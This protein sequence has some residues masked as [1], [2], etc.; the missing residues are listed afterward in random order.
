M[1]EG[2][3]EGTVPE[4][5]ERFLAYLANERRY[6]PYTVRNYRQALLDLAASGGARRQ[7]EAPVDLRTLLHRD[8][9]SYIVEAQ[10]SG[11]SPRTLHLRLSAIRSFY[12]YLHR[13]GEVAANPATGLVLPSYRKPLPKFF[14]PSQI[15]S[16]L[17]APSRLLAEDRIDAFTAARDEAVFELFYGAGLRISEL[18]EARWGHA[19]FAARCLRVVGKGRKERICP[20]GKTAAEKLQAFRDRH[21]VVRG[22]NDFL[23]HDAVG[24]PL[25]AWRIQRDMKKYLR[26]S[27]LPDDLTPHKIRHSFATH[28]LDAGADLRAVQSMLGHASLSTTQIY[29][30]VGL[31]RLKA[32]HKQAHPRA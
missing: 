6:S 16:F 27:G 13:M 17:E 11:T 19:D 1:S 31:D 25:S 23:V 7:Q 2:E 30:H 20:M 4:L 18:M 32:A 3:A 28:L 29:T 12:R 26:A 21:A 5:V 8:L 15:R 10:R 9:R 24:K 14:S 22:T